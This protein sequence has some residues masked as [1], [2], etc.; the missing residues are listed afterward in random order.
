MNVRGLGR[1]KTSELIYVDCFQQ[2]DKKVNNIWYLIFVIV[3]VITSLAK[4]KFPF[5]SSF[6]FGISS[7]RTGDV[8]WAVIVP[9]NILILFD[10]SDGNV[11][12][13]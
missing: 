10:Q 13:Y 1:Y 9:E 2:G 6:F 4:G 12:T 5:A 7:E 3:I 11:K 8:T